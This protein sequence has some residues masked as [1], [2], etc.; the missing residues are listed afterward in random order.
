MLKQTIGLFTKTTNAAAFVTPWMS[1]QAQFPDNSYETIFREGYGKNPI[2]FACIEEWAT[3]F[4]EPEL[5]AYRNTP[6]GPEVV[7]DHPAVALWNNPNPWLSGDDL[8]GGVQMY[9]RMA[10][11]SY[12]LKVRSGARKTVELWQPRPDRMRVIPDRTQ[13]I[14]GYQYRN[15]A[16]TIDIPA[17]DVIHLKTRHPFN[18]FYGMPPLMAAAGRVDIDNFMGDIIKGFLR[19]SGVPAG[20]M[21]IQGAVSEQEKALFRSRFRLDFGGDSSGNVMVINGPKDAVDYQPLAMPLGAR[22]LVIPELDEMSEARIAMVFRVPQSI[23]NS[24][25]G[26]S[27]SSYGNRKSDREEFTQRQLVPEWQSVASAL[28]QSL[29]PEFGGADFLAFDLS[30]VQALAQD[31]TALSERIV[32]EVTSG[33]RSREEGRKAIG[34]P[35]DADPDDTFYVPTTVTPT[36]VGVETPDQQ[37]DQL[38]EGPDQGTLPIRSTNGVHA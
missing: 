7:A 30:T 31:M 6:N 1:G 4:A 2:V 27:S 36:P 25:L 5:R 13:Y 16:E 24:R 22:G 35:P 33:I 8:A 34:L 15:G 3:D 32:K 21:R 38:P 19:N 12:I 10:G 18:D 11:N 37:P 9:K 20:I 29:L 23:L 26:M 14:R 17:A 28:T